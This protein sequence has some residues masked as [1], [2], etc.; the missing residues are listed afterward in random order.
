[1]ETIEIAREEIWKYRQVCKVL[2]TNNGKVTKSEPINAFIK[3]NNI[4]KLDFKK[5]T[6]KPLFVY[7]LFEENEDYIELSIFNL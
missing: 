4:K 5:Y 3:K 1:M 2:K 7:N 6:I